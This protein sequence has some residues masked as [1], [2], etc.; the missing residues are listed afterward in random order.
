MAPEQQT[1]KFQTKNPK[2]FA[3]GVSFSLEKVGAIVSRAIGAADTGEVVGSTVAGST[4]TVSDA[5]IT[6]ALVDVGGMAS[7][8][9]GARVSLSFVGSNVAKSC[10]SSTTSIRVSSAG[11]CLASTQ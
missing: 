2:V 5:C 10:I 9:Y 8:G 11:T 6:T 3:G 1:F 4:V 7:G